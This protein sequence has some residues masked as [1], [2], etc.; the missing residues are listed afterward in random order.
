MLDSSDCRPPATADS[1]NLRDLPFG[2]F[3]DSSLEKTG[4]P[5][6]PVILCSAGVLARV[7]AQRASSISM[8]QGFGRSLQK[9]QRDSLVWG[10]V[11]RSAGSGRIPALSG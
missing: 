7:N 5:Q 4:P 6:L 1:V 3:C 10:E 11:W 9:D 8:L 2:T